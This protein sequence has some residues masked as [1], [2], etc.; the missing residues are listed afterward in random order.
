MEGLSDPEARAL[1][2]KYGYNELVEIRKRSVLLKFLEQFRD[3]PVIILIVALVVSAVMG[4]VVD[5]VAIGIIVV[6]NAT[7]GFVQEYRAE[8]A[9][10][11]LKKMAAPKAKVYRN[12]ELVE[13]EAREIVPGDLVALDA[14]DA[15]PA[16]IEV[17]EAFNLQVNEA[18]LTGESVPVRKE[19]GASLFMGCVVT[20]GRA[21]G[22]VTT[23]GMSTNSVR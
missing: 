12:G 8:K 20:N 1:L 17:D 2:E 21:K 4:E 6:L 19:K 14:G 15:I 23:T 7:L 10:E 3:I 5:A 16:D 18:P 9:L 13:L 22:R 11:A